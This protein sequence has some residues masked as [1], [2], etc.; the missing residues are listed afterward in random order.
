VVHASGAKNES[1][2]LT[3]MSRLI[4]F[5]DSFTYGHWLDHDDK[6]PSGRAWPKLLGNMLG[7]EVVNK[8]VPG[9]SNIQILRNI[10]NFNDYQQGD[11]VIVGWTYALRDYIFR[12]NLLGIDTSIQVSPWYKDEKFIMKWAEVHNDYDLSIRAGLYMHHAET[13]LKTKNIRQKHFCAYQ[14]FFEVLP[15]FTS[16]LDT[17]ITGLILPRIDKAL[18]GDHPGPKSHYQAAQSLYE[19]LNATE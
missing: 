7:C 1:G 15:N 19:I 4:T 3:K 5:G 17:F 13:F 6:N 10:L 11:V 9:Y 16:E 2:L 18:D 12:K 14:G 8:S